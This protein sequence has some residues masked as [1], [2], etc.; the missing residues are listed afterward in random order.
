MA[1]SGEGLGSRPGPGPHFPPIHPPSRSGPEQALPWIPMFAFLGSLLILII[2]SLE[3]FLYNRWPYSLLSSRWSLRLPR[4]RSS[5]LLK[6]G[7]KLKSLYR[8]Q[9]HVL[10]NNAQEYSC[11]P[12]RLCNACYS[13]IRKSGLIFGSFW[14]VIPKVER[15]DM[16]HSIEDFRQ[17]SMALCHLC[18]ILWHAISMGTKRRIQSEDEAL[19]AHAQDSA[20]ECMR[21]RLVIFEEMLSSRSL[22]DWAEANPLYMQVYRGAEPISSKLEVKIG[23]SPMRLASI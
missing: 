20:K 21:I 9:D 11:V 23:T 7:S 10:D 8:T 2:I 14:T 5:L 4:F 19:I 6:D 16:Y 17:S 18:G 1:Y 15:K 22:F 3:A 13:A 12:D